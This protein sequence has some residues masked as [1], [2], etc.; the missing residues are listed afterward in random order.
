MEHS[1]QAMPEPDTKSK[2]ETDPN[3]SRIKGYASDRDAYKGLRES[4][5]TNSES[6]GTD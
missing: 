1:K 4:G 6:R 2:G 5:E 3:A